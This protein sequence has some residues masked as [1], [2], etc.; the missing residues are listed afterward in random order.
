[1]RNDYFV[2]VLALSMA[3]VLVLYY[4]SYTDKRYV[5][6]TA[7]NLK[8]RIDKKLRD[9]IPTCCKALTKECLSCAAGLL[10]HDFCLRHQGEYGCLD[11]KTRTT[12]PM[13][14]PVTTRVEPNI[15]IAI[16]TYNRIGY[17]KFHANIIRNYHKIPANMLYIFDD[18]STEYGERE[19]RQW[20]GNNIN[21]F[22]CKKRLK[23]DANIRRMFKFFVD[24]E[25]DIIFSVDTDLLFQLNWKEFIL[26]H[27]GETDGVMSLYHSSAPH[28][29]TIKCGKYLCE[30]KSM[31]SA[32]TVMTKN[33][34]K[35]MLIKNQ[36]KLFDWGFVDFFKQRKVRMMV[37]KRSLVFHYGQFGQ[38]NGCGTKEVAKYFDRSKLPL[39]IRTGL[40]FFF[41]KCK[42]PSTIFQPKVLCT[43]HPKGKIWDT[44][45]DMVSILNK[46]DAPYNLHGGTLLSWYRDCSVGNQDIDF[47]LDLK[48]FTE[49]NKLLAKT[50]KNN[51]WRMEHAYG[52]FGKP[53]YE[54]AWLKRNIKVDLFSQAL[55]NGKHTTGM[56]VNGITYPCMITKTGTLTY[57]WADMQIQVPEPIEGVLEQLYTDW[58]TPL[59]KYAWD[60]DPFKKGNQCTKTFTL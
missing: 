12:T 46:I 16:P 18:C 30:K 25:F 8:R 15:M 31:G 38:N 1:M 57:K 48:W 43:T 58:K 29:K 50:L 5:Y 40:M 37:P 53:G 45:A 6:D 42:K 4:S 59:K 7:S 14:V 17:T 60:I 26:T 27:I 54:E 51:G 28:H 36:N 55:L 22:P 24:T 13:L 2:M 21:F 19:L 10:V 35:K 52:K 9:T 47:T 44:F 39:W 11:N 32:G 20:Y 33:I 34:V 23:S 49:H 3:S 41:D 56:T